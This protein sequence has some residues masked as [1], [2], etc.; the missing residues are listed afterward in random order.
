MAGSPT[1]ASED[2]YRKDSDHEGG[3]VLAK[4]FGTGTVEQRP[5]GMRGSS[6]TVN[7]QLAHVVSHELSQPLTTI[8]GFA[9]LLA[10]RYEDRLDADA[11]EFIRFIVAGARRMQAM[12]DDLQTYLSVGDSEPPAAPVDCARVV[13]VAVDSL[14][15]PMAET[16]ATVTVGPL[17]HCRGDSVQIGHLFRQL[18]SNALKFTGDQRPRISVSATRENGH[19]R[20]SVVD[21]GRGMEHSWSERAFELFESLHPSESAPGT[22]AGLAICKRIVERHGGEIWFD[23][24]AEIG[25]RFQFTI[26]DRGQP[27]S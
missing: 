11:D 26:P 18:L 9:D 8:A 2:N 7:E 14:A 3:G 12:L 6:E 5:N 17:P 19:V 23:P 27:A 1:S 15:T 25:S 24:A 16:R 20:F 13:Q 22:G 21:N 10:R 4:E